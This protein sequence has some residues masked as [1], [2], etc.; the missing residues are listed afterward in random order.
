MAAVVYITSNNS[1]SFELHM[2]VHYFISTSHDNV[3][4][5]FLSGS[6]ICQGAPR[7]GVWTIGV[8]IIL[9]LVTGRKKVE[10]SSFHLVKL[11]IWW[12]G[13]PIGASIGHC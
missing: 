12:G 2:H 13:S 4:D 8:G 1:I 11:W 7:E 3:S 10:L 5:E 6:N 9:E